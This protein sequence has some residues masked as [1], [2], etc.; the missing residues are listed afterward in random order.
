MKNLLNIKS[1]ENQ[2]CLFIKNRSCEILRKRDCE[3]C[4]FFKENTP[5]NYQKCI[6]EVK[7]Q[8]KKYALE[9]K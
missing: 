4:K 2:N 1:K 7:E 8:I 5:E 3:N 6:V 9:H